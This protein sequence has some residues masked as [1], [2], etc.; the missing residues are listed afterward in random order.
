MTRRTRK[1]S[2]HTDEEIGTRL[3][4]FRNAKHLSQTQL[5]DA[6]GVSF[7]QVQKY[8][9]G[10][11]RISGGSL[12]KICQVLSVKP[13]QILGNGTGIFHDDP[14]LLEP[15]RDHTTAKAFMIISKLPRHQRVAVMHCLVMLCNAF[16]GGK[17]K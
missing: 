4:V 11:N 8:E 7:Q 14:D 3:R 15:L 16:S 9:R 10:I 5:G 1:R 17:L 6:L 12:V 2:T 13:E